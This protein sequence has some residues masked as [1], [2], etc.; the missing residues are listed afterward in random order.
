MEK[1][2]LA[3]KT[4]KL[5]INKEYENAKTGA[6]YRVEDWW[7]NVSGGQSWMDCNGNPACMIYGMRSGVAGLPIDDKVLY[8][9]IDGAGYLI[10]ESEL[11]NGGKQ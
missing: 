9:K 5:K 1:S 3:G 4:V 2:K 6:E 7:I 10:H 8:G 11:E